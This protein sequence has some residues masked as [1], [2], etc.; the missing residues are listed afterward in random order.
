VII[1]HGAN[2]QGADRHAADWARENEIA[3][4]PHPADWAR[5]GRAA[6]PIRNQEMIDAGADVCLAFPLP[7]SRG[8]V[9]CIRRAKE[10]GITV[11]EAAPGR[12]PEATP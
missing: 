10:A 5:H 2:L 3:Q 11:I 12:A 4:E 1:V 9:D 8:T 6:G 7:Q